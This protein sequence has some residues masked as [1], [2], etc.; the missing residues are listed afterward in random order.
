MFSYI[1]YTSSFRQ[2]ALEGR[3]ID[4]HIPHRPQPLPA[5]LLLLQQLLPAGHIRGVEL[6]QHVLAEGLDGF[7]GNDFVSYDG[8]DDDLCCGERVS[9]GEGLGG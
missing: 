9:M 7:S 8:L 4:N 1:T 3:L 5:L 2:K 6:G